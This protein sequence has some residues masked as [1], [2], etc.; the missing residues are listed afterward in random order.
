MYYNNGTQVSFT[1]EE[2]Q[3]MAKKMLG[4]NYTTFCGVLNRDA[5]DAKLLFELANLLDMSASCRR[6]C[7]CSGGFQVDGRVLACGASGRL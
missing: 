3:K 2:Q 7:G 4:R 1:A 6:G 5:V